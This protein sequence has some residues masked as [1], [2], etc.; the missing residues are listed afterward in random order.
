MP[1][2]EMWI[3]EARGPSNEW[4]GVRAFESEAAARDHVEYNNSHGAV[5]D[6]R[7]APYVPRRGYRIAVVVVALACLSIWIAW[8]LLSALAGLL[9][10]LYKFG[11]AL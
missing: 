1:T 6:Y 2:R 7:V 5:L 10:G 8:P 9:A 11:G 4:F 3:V